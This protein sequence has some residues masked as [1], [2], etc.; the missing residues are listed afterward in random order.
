MPKLALSTNFDTST[1]YFA[2]YLNNYLKKYPNPNNLIDLDM[3]DRQKLVEIAR[4]EEETNKIMAT[5]NNNSP[6][7]PII[8]IEQKG[9]IALKPKS[10][11]EAK[12][13]NPLTLADASNPNDTLTLRGKSTDYQGRLKLH[14]VTRSLISA[15]ELSF[16]IGE[17]LFDSS[18]IKYPVF[19]KDIEANTIYSRLDNFGSFKLTNSEMSFNY[20]PLEENNIFK[21]VTELEFRDTMNL[22]SNFLH[23]PNQNKITKK[24]LVSKLG[25]IPIIYHD[26]LDILLVSESKSEPL[27]LATNDDLNNFKERWGIPDDAKVM[28]YRDLNETYYFYNIE[29][30]A[31]VTKIKPVGF[32]KVPARENVYIYKIED[33][34]NVTPISIKH[35]S[36][37]LIKK[38]DGC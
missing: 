9:N 21:M 3:C 15:R 12:L 32:K 5:L 20:E 23:S 31:K 14:I 13:L 2:N 28:F 18:N 11:L 36:F 10:K 17:L 8:I 37:T 27:S 1:R 29:P 38:I 33:N 6:L 35:L 24:G 16:Y 25:G 19:I 22:Y 34:L 26:E 30:I 7:L 4:S